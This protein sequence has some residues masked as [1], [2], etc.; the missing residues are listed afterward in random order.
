MISGQPRERSRIFVKTGDCPKQRIAKFVQ[1][2]K[3]LC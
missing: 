3:S 2:C 1:L